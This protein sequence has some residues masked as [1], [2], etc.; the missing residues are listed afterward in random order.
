LFGAKTEVDHLSLGIEE[1]VKKVADD[2]SR[3]ESLRI[4]WAYQ[5]GQT[6]FPA[7]G[8]TRSN[9]EVRPIKR[10]PG[11]KVENICRLVANQPSASPRRKE[12]P[13][14]RDQRVGMHVKKVWICLSVAQRDDVNIDL[15]R[16]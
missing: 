10:K 14:Y 16:S 2:S 7:K 11:P 12:N 6:G 9:H 8:R 15:A 13:Q 3:E 5:T 4:F 1:I